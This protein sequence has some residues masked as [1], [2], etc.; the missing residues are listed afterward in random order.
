MAVYLTHALEEWIATALLMD[1]GS[2]DHAQQVSV[3]MVPTVETLM[4]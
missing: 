4:R 3:E 1:L 2:V